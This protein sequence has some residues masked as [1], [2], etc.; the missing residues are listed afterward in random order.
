MNNALFFQALKCLGTWARKR[1]RNFRKWTWRGHDAEVQ[2]IA[3]L[4][5]GRVLSGSRDHVCSTLDTGNSIA[6]LPDGRLAQPCEGGTTAV[7]SM[8]SLKLWNVQHRHAA[9]EP[10][11]RVYIGGNLGIATTPRHMIHAIVALADGRYITG[12]TD[13]ALKVWSAPPSS[14]IGKPL[15]SE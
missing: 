11:R 7:W 1:V 6:I 10:S 8:S 5:D 2:A 13:G 4:S 14:G 15:D 12:A 9:H 3:L